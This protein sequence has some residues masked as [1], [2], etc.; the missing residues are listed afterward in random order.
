MK[1]LVTIL[2]VFLF[3]NSHCQTLEGFLG[4]KFGST[5]EEATK[6]L[7]AKPGFKVNREFSKPDILAF[8]DAPFAGRKS[9]LIC[10]AFVNNKFHTGFAI[11]AP[12]LESQLIELYNG[13]KEELNEKYFKT[14]SDFKSFK[15][16][17]ED[18]D[19]HEE[20]AIKLGKASFSSFWNFKNPKGTNDENNIISLEITESMKVKLT[21]Q[22]GILIHEQVD[23]AKKKN[24]Q[25][26]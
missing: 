17:Y 25:D 11:I 9:F 14:T 6:I 21:Y 19:G 22:D 5:I 24:F 10:L 2:I 3:I 16:P 13:I 7:S 20:T 26:Y 8:T 1:S 23:K 4:V 12:N 18:G 15:Y